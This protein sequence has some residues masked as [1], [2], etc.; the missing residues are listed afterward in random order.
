MVQQGQ[1]ALTSVNMFLV[2]TIEESTQVECGT[3]SRSG[4]YVEV[5]GHH[6]LLEPGHGGCCGT[7]HGG[8]R[9]VC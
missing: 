6:P 5:D 9:R 4:G 8:V 2:P 3:V 7:P 1:V